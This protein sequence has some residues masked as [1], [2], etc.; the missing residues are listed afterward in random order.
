M[1]TSQSHFVS[2]DTG[3]PQGSV[4]GPLLFSTYTSPIGQLIKS[5]G[6]LHQQYADDTQEFIVENIR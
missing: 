2:L 4:L 5:F 3:V 1:G 6:I